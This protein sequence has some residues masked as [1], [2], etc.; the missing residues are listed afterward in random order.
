[1]IDGELNGAQVGRY[2]IDV[3]KQIDGIKIAVEYDSWYYHGGTGARD[4]RKDAIL[5]AD[6]WRVLRIR[7]NKL[8]PS[9]EQVN[10]ALARLVG[11][12]RWVDIVLDD[13]GKGPTRVCLDG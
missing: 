5:L 8:L 1:M 7:S 6:E 9:R 10:E 3:T 2:K 11:G 13:W 4:A 12:E